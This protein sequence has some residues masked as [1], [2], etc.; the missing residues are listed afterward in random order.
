MPVGRVAEAAH[1]QGPPESGDL[2]GHHEEVAIGE[3]AQVGQNPGHAEGSGRFEVGVDP[4]AGE[5]STSV[6][7]MRAV[8]CRIRTKAE[9]TPPRDNASGPHDHQ[10]S[11]ST[12]RNGSGKVNGAS[13]SRRVS[14]RPPAQC[15][16]NRT[17]QARTRTGMDATRRRPREVSGG[18]RWPGEGRR[19][20]GQTPT[21]VEPAQPEESRRGGR[22][23]ASVMGARLQGIQDWEPSQPLLL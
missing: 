15:S 9:T 7:V 11:T 5:G 20:P 4:G 23:S 17:S 22:E 14:N 2:V 8:A 3:E 16:G 19:Q 18:G 12:R 21:G 13:T 10:G 1:P 6:R